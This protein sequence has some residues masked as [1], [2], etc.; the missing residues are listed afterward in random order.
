MIVFNLR[1]PKDHVSE[2]WFRDSAAYEGQAAARKI[3]CPVCGSTKMTKAPMAPNVA[4]GATPSVRPTEE[5]G[6]TAQLHQKLGELRRCIEDNF[7]NVGRQFP[8][9]ARKIHYGEAEPRNIYGESTDQEARTLAEEGIRIAK[10]PWL[11][12]HDS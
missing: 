12:R 3:S 10:I 11:R 2:I 4:K 9:E 5:N 7:D 6:R 1:C 8:E